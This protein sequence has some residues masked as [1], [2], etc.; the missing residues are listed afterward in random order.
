MFDFLKFGRSGKIHQSFMAEDESPMDGEV[1]S[2]ERLQGRAAEL[3]A[4]HR[5]VPKEKRGFDLLSRL[6]DNKNELVKVYRALSDTARDELLTPSADWLV[7]NFHIVEEQ[8]REVRQDLPSKFYRE[9]PKLENGAF[10]NYPRIYHLAYEV[11]A[12]TDNR[13]DA[14][15]LE[16]FLEAYQQHKPLTIGEIWAFP[17]SLRLALIENLRRFAIRI[18]HARLERMAADTLAD[19]LDKFTGKEF[20]GKTFEL[21]A[22]N[23]D[24]GRLTE[25][26]SR[27]FLVQIAARLHEG[28]DFVGYELEKLERRL[29][30]EGVTL[31]H[32]SH[33]EHNRQAAAQVSVANII[34][35]MRLLS[36]LDWRDFFESVSRVDRVLREEDPAN[37]YG[38]MD[39][40]TRDSYR[41][42]IERIAKRTQTDEIK[43][44]RQ[45]IAFAAAHPAND[46]RRRHVGYYLHIE[47]GLAM[48]EHSVNCSRTLREHVEYW[49]HRRPTTFYLTTI[50]ALTMFFLILTVF[51]VMQPPIISFSAWIFIALLALIPA[52][53]LAITF[54]NRIINA[55]LKPRLLPK[56]DL[57]TGIPEK[58]RTIVVVPT[59]L[60][61]KATITELCGNL[62]VYHLANRDNELFFALLGDLQDADGETMPND[63]E[64][65]EWTR[66]VVAQLNEKYKAGETEPR[67]HFFTRRREW[68]AGEGKWICRE[69][70][71]GNLHEFNQL[72]R[73]KTDT[74]FALDE[75]VDFEFLKTIRY[76]IT[77][78]ADTQ[79]PR[80][81]ARKLI[82]TIEH[83]LN[84][85]VF[86]EKVGRVT[87]GYAILQPRIEISL[88]SSLQTTFARIFSASKGF[89][90]YTTA[91]SD[92]YQDLF[93][94]GSFVGKGLYDVDAFEAALDRRIP[95]NKLLSHDLFEGLY[96]R[97]ALLTD[98]A[99]YDDYPSTYESYAKRNHRWT[100][101]DWQIARWLLPFVPNAD[102]RI[103]RNHLP[104]IARWK[105][106]DNLRRSLLAP[107]LLLW[108]FSAWTLTIISPL[109]AELFVLI[110][111]TAPLYLHVAT[112]SIRPT[113]SDRW[114]HALIHFSNL[115]VD[116]KTIVTHMFFRFAF[117]AHDAALTIDAG[118]RVAY[119]KLI[120]EKRLLEWV[121]AA[122]SE[123][124]SGKN[125]SSYFLFMAAS[126]IISL[127]IL[128]LAAV[129][130]PANLIVAVPFL[131]L[132]AIAPFIA[133]RLSLPRI[134]YAGIK[135]LGAN[136]IKWLRL[137][138]RRTWRYFET[139][140]G[141]REHWLPP[142]NFQQ[143]PQDVIAHRTSPTN[144]GLL[145][146]S[147]LAARDFGY[148]GTLEAI[149]RIELTCM[150]LERLARFRGHFYN[151]YDTQT[152]EP[153]VPQYIS[154]VDSGN[155]AGHLIAVAEGCREFADEPL[156]GERTL[157]GFLD[158]IDFLKSE[159][160][161]IEKK[162]LI[163]A[164]TEL[165]TIKTAVGDCENILS[166]D[167]PVDQNEWQSLFAVLTMNGE[168]IAEVINK[169]PEILQEFSELMFWTTALMG[170]AKNYDRDL[171][172]LMP[173]DP[174]NGRTEQVETAR[175]NFRARVESI[176][177]FCR[178]ICDEMDFSFLYDDEKKVLTIGYR[179]TENVRDN[180][181]YDLLASEARLASFIAV[182]SGDVD[183]EHWFRLGRGLVGSKGNR[184]LVS[185]S[186]TMF[187]Y[188]M[189]LLVMQNYERTLLDETYRAVVRRQIEYGEENGIAW[190]VSESAYNARDLQ[191]NYQ[192]APFGVPGLGLKR[193]LAAD[194]VVAP[195]ATALALPFQLKAAI[196][197][198][199]RL[200]NEGM[201][202]RYG[203]FE[204][205]DYTQS[206][207]PPK[208][209]SARVE[210]YMSHH[211]GMI[212]VA[213]DNVLHD[214][215]MQKRF[216]RAPMVESADLL[217]QERVPRFT[218]EAEHPPDAEVLRGSRNDRSR[219][220][221]S[222]IPRR[223]SSANQP[224]PQVC[225]LSNGNYT[226]MLTT[227]GSGFSRWDNRA[228]TR[229]REDVVRDDS[230]HYFY[231]RDVRSGAIWSSGFQPTLREPQDYKVIFTESKAEFRRRDA[232]IST[233][234]EIIVA[235]E[236]NAELRRITVTNESSRTREIEV[237]SYAE[238]VL[239]E[240]AAD[241]SHMA[242]NKMF[243]ET[244]YIAGQQ[245]ILARR[246][247]RSTEETEVWGAQT[248]AVTGNTIGEINFETDRLQFLG[249]NRTAQNP[250]S[251]S[252]DTE[253]AGT[254]G[255][256]LDPI[257]S[258]SVR[259]SIE[260]GES[261]ILVFSTVVADSRE[262]ALILS[263]KYRDA[264][265]FDRAE[266]LVWTRSQVELR[267]LGISTAEANLFQRLAGHLIYEDETLRPR[268]RVLKLNKGTQKDL[269]KYG[270][271]G[272]L[273]LMIV[274][275]SEGKDA[276][277][278]IRQILRGHSYLHGKKL[279]FDLLIL[280]DQPASYEQS[281]NED[282]QAMIRSG[283]MQT[284]MDTPGGIFLRRTDIMTEADR[285]TLHTAAR[286]CFVTERGTL[287]EELARNTRETELP[288]LFIQQKSSRVYADPA[289][290]VPKIVF[291]NELGGF[292]EQ[293][294]EYCI[295]LERDKS[296][297]APWTN[298]IS[299][300]KG[301]GFLTTETGSGVTWSNNSRENR[302][303]GWSN[304][305]ASNPPPECVFLR[306]EETGSFWT[307]TAL[308]IRENSPY[309]ITHGS[310][311]SIYAHTSHGI[312][313]ELLVFVPIDGN[314]KIS[315]LRLKNITAR[316]R[317]ISA[318]Y[319]A[320]L[321]LGV[322]RDQ[323]APFVIT[324]IDAVTGAIL[325]RNPYNNEFADRVAF[326]ATSAEMRTWTCDRQEFIGRNGTLAR[327]AAMLRTN[328][329]G[330]NGAGLDP[331][332]AIQTDIEIQPGETR[333]IVFVLGEEDSLENARHSAELFRQKRIVGEE[334]SSVKEFWNKTLNA[335]QVKTPDGAMNIMM[336]RW[337]LY[338]TLAC[339]FWA[340]TA[341]YQSSGAFGFRDQ[342][343]DSMALVYTRPDL[344]RA[345]ILRA[346][347]HQFKE[348]DVQHWWHEPSNAGTRTRISD[349]L[350]WLVYV[351]C[352]YVEKTAD[353]S[354]FDEVVSFL[355]GRV[356]ATGEMETY[357][358]P[359]VS[360]E[361][362]T[363]FEHCVRAVE[364]SLAM[365]V[366][367][368]P[369]IGAG[370]WS[371]GL[372]RV[373]SAGK[374]ESVWLGW[375]LAKSLGDFAEVCDARNEAERAE[376]YR[377][378]AKLLIKNLE[379][380]AW[381]G[382]WY[383]R[384]FFDDGTPLGS[385]QN[386]EC[387][388][389]SIAQSWSVISGKGKKERSEQAMQ[390][391]V[392]RLIKRAEKLV[393]LLDPPFDKSTLEPG[394]IKGYPP[395]IRENGGQYTHAA[396]WTIIAFALLGDGDKA[397]EIFSLLNPIN[398]TRTSEDI[399][400]YKTEP[401]SVAADVYSNPQHV[402]RGGW[403]WYTGAAGWLYRAALENILG[404]HKYGAS[405]VI[406]PCIPHYW[407]EFEI[408][409]QYKT[410]TYHIKVE[411]PHGVC[412]GSLEIEADGE[413][414]S[415][416]R[417]E[418]VDDGLTHDVRII[419]GDA[420]NKETTE[421]IRQANK[422]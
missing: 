322:N 204:A 65:C 397:F 47:E 46:E 217:L 175:Q 265:V 18:L 188:L 43:V 97:V 86:D 259:V 418:L 162:N 157:K 8:L 207:L 199:R 155:L 376:K 38:K 233:H 327:P 344:A 278:G 349:N 178:R 50:A 267:H 332:A 254:A 389:D 41:H 89:D 317:Q 331:C 296:T 326:V 398:H 182:A 394:Y 31:E 161:Q 310:G 262:K 174:A 115:W 286:V 7:D 311:F 151:W 410:A 222:P 78:D 77:L 55:I 357:L 73:G 346:A 109:A 388:I 141:E 279:M 221:V 306:D 387:Q 258:L 22:E 10:E 193:G 252:R 154:T 139:F 90:P 163:T 372:N 26:F 36:T 402:G 251:V 121:T 208:Q 244:E 340:R 345:H 414:L 127:I 172:M 377:S 44:A 224:T 303:T 129:F 85:P 235:T 213:L 374:G 319:F 126:P 37:A 195:Y 210:T 226:V 253:K 391:V 304:D 145:L 146:L 101:G 5:I 282:L 420:A 379:K 309:L 318:T 170:L 148:T 285:I 393:L 330:A 45:A 287:E 299:N 261:A 362:A 92:I 143:D 351:A 61:N 246:R 369:L 350:I 150:T 180:S 152:L 114:K 385:R 240:Q 153:L 69:R 281:F 111:L 238:I 290:I 105:I 96:A 51:A 297:P 358:R 355:D 219:A 192:Y 110:I 19:E 189:P 243:V 245:T 312:A 360:G 13:L 273:P 27:A 366:H 183:Q 212:I 211:Q 337:L 220:L 119:R 289:E 347:A 133:F 164:S 415:S 395:G 275:V 409:Y 307:P 40:A 353:A 197:N 316:T 134:E 60:T 321:V 325:V 236:D 308:P 363:V 117:L 274:R 255:A 176:A 250:L 106:L 142:D 292:A 361:T 203:F 421:E 72:L 12:D 215:V 14:I 181:F 29:R 168:V 64:L 102:G 1:F 364:K 359:V 323:S 352:F 419:L 339:R 335:I 422:V 342:L 135:E 17:I 383:L 411:N 57:K 198:L 53:E 280:N 24:G 408:T 35:S 122:Q 216:H 108:L 185:W 365:G 295:K 54:V 68:N 218:E 179:P 186:G 209:A 191:L 248:V 98:V 88:T 42:H 184:S 378:H 266:K 288:P 87:E 412:G 400:Q 336:N 16:A 3:A 260:P 206:R 194:L 130:H 334:F 205:M 156:F 406:E 20:S 30:P 113:E 305:A 166:K 79:L 392:E 6:E 390:S 333:E 371:D 91:V 107:T 83:P 149:E 173:P 187:E 314:V 63:A 95:E 201:F 4:T 348:G 232:G 25:K 103:V 249:R 159:V 93:T 171:Q 373:G 386:D 239:N 123:Q 15:T 343:Q 247:P 84:R 81:T 227:A 384:A 70:K 277:S 300:E 231:L 58:A 230:G 11:V 404:F 396:A 160:E 354:I 237:T 124:L 140:V 324:E 268:P 214:N 33:Q 271:S 196:A 228:V 401:Y 120:S 167:L 242:F 301:F 413:T 177:V 131:L 62:E 382:D 200:A 272:D 66:Q 169:T 291:A 263:D 225:L 165:K 294:S 56:M 223:Y 302:L 270:I 276:R 52:S 136:D 315:R 338:Q 99:L 370:D 147:T 367:G 293:G 74:S 234:T 403:T 39:F 76:V 380:N 313:Q 100:R 264:N 21:L 125:L 190:G 381:D 32:L 71:R 283:G 49:L 80:D 202:A 112:A 356:L 138:A 269:W 118:W 405:L 329:S 116:V 257:F 67:F 241:E 158:T 328:L 132:W 256:T 48:L 416:D 94:E 75:A 399:A 407:K 2:L 104:L 284:Q 34:T 341:F 144:I 59:F 82:G 320:E 128:A 9:L 298:V 229:W 368:L 137:A 375:F 23:F 28:D 417:I